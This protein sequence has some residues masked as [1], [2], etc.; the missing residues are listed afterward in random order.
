VELG[1]NGDLLYNIFDLILCILDVDYFDSN[2]LPSSLVNPDTKLAQRLR[3][4]RRVGGKNL[5]LVDF[6]KTAAACK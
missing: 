4:L 2:S 6:S 3:Y 1:E 5:P